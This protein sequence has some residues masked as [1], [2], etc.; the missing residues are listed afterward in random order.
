MKAYDEMQSWDVPAFA[1]AC[2]ELEALLAI[3]KAY[4]AERHGVE[5]RGLIYRALGAIRVGD[6]QAAEDALLELLEANGPS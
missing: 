4:V 1:L 2:D 3:T 5:H 6:L